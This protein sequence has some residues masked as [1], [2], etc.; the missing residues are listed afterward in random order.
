M[1]WALEIAFIL[2]LLSFP[3]ILRAYIMIGR[4][5][6]VGSLRPIHLTKAVNDF[7]YILSVLTGLLVTTAFYSTDS[8][9]WLFA[10]F[11][12][13]LWLADLGYALAANHAR[14]LEDLP[15]ER[16]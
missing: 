12:L 2:A 16:R 14:T 6:K 1:S 4:S 5:H 9:K 3:S 7:P 10:S 13:T 15:H 8:I 11:A